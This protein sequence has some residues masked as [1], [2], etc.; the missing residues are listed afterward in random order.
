MSKTR[1]F[2]KYWFVPLAWMSLIFVGSSDSKSY[3]HSSR[4]IEPFLHWLFPHMTQTHVEAI[5]HAIRKCCHL[6]EYAILATLLWRAVRKPVRRDPRPWSWREATIA[7]IIVFL[8]AS[9]DEFHQ[10]FVPTRTPMVSDVFID[11]SG[12]VIG[13]IVLWAAGRRL[14]WWGNREDGEDSPQRT[15]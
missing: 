4:L 7:I 12:A 1:S 5:H 11:T 15:P 2:F 10:M 9:T 3:T 8:Y 14:K 6:T 13:M